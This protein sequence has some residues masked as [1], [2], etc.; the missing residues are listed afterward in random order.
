MVYKVLQL[1]KGSLDANPLFKKTKQ[2]EK[3]HTIKLKVGYLPFSEGEE[4]R[5]ILTGG[6]RGG[7]LDGSI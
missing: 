7:F 5:K 1:H 6:V 2:E 4:K 3:R